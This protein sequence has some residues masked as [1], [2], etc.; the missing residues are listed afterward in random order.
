MKGK[1]FIISGPSGSGKTTLGN[2][3]VKNIEN[4]KFSVSCTTRPIRKDE[5]NGVDYIFI[6]ENEFQDMVKCGK[7]AEWAEVHGNLYGT[8]VKN[9]NDA[10]KDGIDVLLDID[11]QGAE[12]LKEK[13]PEAVFIFVVPPSIEVLQKRLL[14]RNS[15]KRNDIDLRLNKVKY[16]IAKS[17]GYD[18][19]II[20]DDMKKAAKT[21][22]SIILFEKRSSET[23]N[24]KN[25]EI[26]EIACG[27]RSI[28]IYNNI[29]LK[30]FD[31]T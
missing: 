25:N 6:R 14:K 11:V 13:F 18:Y 19:I 4:L 22:E 2:H 28:N 8:P 27:S 16:E 26:E 17:K 1:L 7:F 3:A 23:G 15:E 31:L 9:I 20:N 5:T 30:R 21:I 12:Q 10:N 24:R 29:I